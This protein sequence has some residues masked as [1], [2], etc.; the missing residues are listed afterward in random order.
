MLESFLRD[1]ADVPQRLDE[2]LRADD[3]D[4]VV[5]LRMVEQA[6]TLATASEKISYGYFR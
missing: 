6:S 3:T 1:N 2:C 4:A 5:T